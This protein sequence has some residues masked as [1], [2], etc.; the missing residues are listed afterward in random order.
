VS[1]AVGA[2]VGGSL[3]LSESENR[4]M[5]PAS[6]RLKQRAKGMADE[7]LGL[8]REAAEHFASDLGS[9]FGTDQRQSQPQDTSADFETVIGGG[10][11]EAPTDPHGGR[12]PPTPSL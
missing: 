6:D 11:P 5:G 1:L 3:R 9:Q 7:Q 2:A 8:A 10:Q 12:R 4:L